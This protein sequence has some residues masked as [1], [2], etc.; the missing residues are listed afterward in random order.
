MIP[1]PRAQAA[2]S[3]AVAHVHREV[4]ARRVVHVGAGLPQA[5]YAVYPYGGKNWLCKG[6]VLTYR[7]HVTREGQ[8]LTNK[9]WTEM[10]P[11]IPRPEWTESFA[12]P[13]DY[14]ASPAETATRPAGPTKPE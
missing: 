4:L 7:E 11:R 10:L 13:P 1:V 8:T 5:I 14:P 6:G 2:R 9:E 12:L 3:Q